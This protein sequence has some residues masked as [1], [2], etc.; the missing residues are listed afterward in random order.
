MNVSEIKSHIGAR[1]AKPFS[2]FDSK[3]YAALAN[4]GCDITQ[5]A[6]SYSTDALDPTYTGGNANTP[7]QFLQNWLPGFVKNLTTARK[8]DELLGITTIGSWEDEEIVQ[9]T[10]ERTGKAVPYGDTS[11]IPLTSYN[12]GFEKRTIVRFEEGMQVTKLDEA[13]IAKMGGNDS[14]F[15]RDAAMLSLEILRN[16]VGFN[17]Y[18]D[19]ENKTYGILNDPNL[20]AY[21]NLPNGAAAASEWATKTFLEITADLRGAFQDLRTQSGGNIDP[22]STAITLAIATS[23]VDYLSTTSDHGVSVYDWMAKAYPSVRVVSVPEFDAANGGDNVFY[24]YSEAPEVDNSTDGNQ[25]IMQLVPNKFMTVG[26][27]QGA[28]GRIEDYSNAL[29]GVLVKRPYLIVR[30]SGC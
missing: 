1:N 25:S 27:E 9:R 23:S 8:I 24:M 15:K 12:F 20:I 13:R 22:T 5:I 28:K 16:K 4:L 30:R 18:N 10:M 7:I 19:G 3:D 14:E 17:G 11:V 29:A 26:V 21:E 6:Q 2:S